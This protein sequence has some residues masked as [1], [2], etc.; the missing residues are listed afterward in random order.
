[1][2]AT[3]WPWQGGARHWWWRRAGRRAALFLDR[4]ALS[5]FRNYRSLEL[6]LPAG[7]VFFRGP[8]GSGKTNLLEA[9]YLLCQGRS[10]RT[11]SDAGLVF[12]GAETALLKAAAREGDSRHELAAA[13]TTAGR[14]HWLN[15]RRTVA[16]Q[17][18][19]RFPVVYVSPEEIGIVS[20]GPALRRAWLDDVGC[21]LLP[22]YRLHWEGF[23]HCLEQ[24]NSLLR[25][26]HTGGGALLEAWEAQLVTHAAAV[27]ELRRA[28]VAELAVLVA[29]EHRSLSGGEVA[30]LAYEPAW[31]GSAG[32]RSSLEEA[33][34]RVL[35]A[36]RPED[37]RRGFTGLGPH[38]DD[39]GMDID[40]REARQYASRGQRRTLLLALKLGCALL[41]ERLS[42]RRAVLLL[43]DVLAELDEGRRRRLVERVRRW[44]QV[45]LTS[46]EAGAGEESGRGRGSYFMVEEGEVRSAAGGRNLFPAVALDSTG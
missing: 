36:N 41:A 1:M 14:E 2:T 5:G 8:N 9:I 17:L 6:N 7:L 35:E 3:W 26:D 45:F 19:A 25:G 11:R 15:G 39:L 42:G 28:L 10:P 46:A 34:L 44:D 22:E 32:D 23:R 21:R 37:E 16:W 31:A 13:I 33:Y 18:S 4:I 38:R 30:R 20:G 24:R 12:F 40:G 43:D 27:G 29:E